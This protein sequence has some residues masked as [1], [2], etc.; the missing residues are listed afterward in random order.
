M[1]S[2]ETQNAAPIAKP[3]IAGKIRPESA[4]IKK[5]FLCCHIMILLLCKSLTFEKS[6]VKFSSSNNIHPICEYQNPFDAL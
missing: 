1:Q 3:I 2:A 6:L 5:T 4:P